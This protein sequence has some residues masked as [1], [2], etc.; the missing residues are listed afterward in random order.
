MIYFFGTTKSKFSL[1]SRTRPN[2]VLAENHRPTFGDSTFSLRPPFG[3][4]PGGWWW[5]R[6]CDGW[7]SFPVYRLRAKR[8]ESSIT[9]SRSAAGLSVV[10][11]ARSNGTSLRTSPPPDDRYTK[12]RGRRETLYTAIILH[13]YTRSKLHRTSGPSEGDARS[14]RRCTR[15]TSTA[16]IE[17]AQ[18]VS[19][20]PARIY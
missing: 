18:R 15:R 12:T 16:A 11:C 8:S 4:P 7:L 20:G 17:F 10:V 3:R 5:R 1:N 19:S 9:R 6:Y 2:G 14:A 13:V